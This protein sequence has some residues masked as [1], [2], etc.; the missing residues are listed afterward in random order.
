MYAAAKPH[1]RHHHK[2]H[3]CP[4]CVRGPGTRHSTRH[5]AGQGSYG[6]PN[7]GLTARRLPRVLR[8][9]P[10]LHPLFRRHLLRPLRVH[11]LWRK[12][13]A[14]R[15]DLPRATDTTSTAD[16]SIA[17][18]AAGAAN[19]CTSSLRHARRWPHTRACGGSNGN[20][21]CRPCCACC[22]PHCFKEAEV[23][24]TAAGQRSTCMC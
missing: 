19:K 16:S 9:P 24:T 21:R 4:A 18:V 20:A 11:L 14:T 17:A 6:P 3:A 23:S 1:P 22:G 13:Q 15:L 10:L 7:R 5:V 8:S 12:Q 2:G